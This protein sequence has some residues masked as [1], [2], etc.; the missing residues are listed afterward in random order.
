MPTYPLI[1]L[2]TQLT[3]P[4][5]PSSKGNEFILGFMGNTA[6]APIDSA[7]ASLLVTTDDPASVEFTVEYFGTTQTMEARKGDVTLVGLPVRNTQDIRVNGED[8]RNKGIRVKATDPTK[9][10]TVYGI[11]DAEVSTDAF[12]ALPCHRYPVTQYNYFVFSTNTIV[13]SMRSRFL[14]VPCEDATT[15]TLRPTQ[16]IEVSADL[17]SDSPIPQNI[18]AGEERSITVNRL[19][20]AQFNSDSDL[21]GTIIVS[22]KPI[23]VFVGHECGQVPTGR[24]ACDH[25]V[26][27]IPPD[28]TW[29]TQ[30][31]TAPLDVRES[32]ERYRVGSVVDNNQVTVTCTTEGQS[33]PSKEMTQTLQSQRGQNYMEFDTVGD[34]P[35]GVTPSYRREYCCIETTKPAIVMMYSKGHSLDEITFQGVTGSQ[36]DPFLLLIPP[37]SQYSNDYTAT[38]AK[39]VNTGFLGHI[40]LTL[41]IQFFDNSTVSRS[42]LTVNGTTYLPDSGYS[43]ILCSNNQV[44]GYGAYSELPVGSHQ[45]NYNMPGAAMNLFVYGFLREISFGYPTGF[46]MEPIGG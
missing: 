23:S 6:N 41:P 38:T 30:F 8:E 10:L 26:E 28:A 45:V 13:A 3:D 39:Q 40:S 21:T 32:G 27:Q 42:R 37:L 4:N 46:E 18:L 11:N 25:L 20:T 5:A 1:S 43:P 31:F 17:L 44:C 34:A 22:D 35:D 9:L 12:L 33:S 24:T 2:R 15:V 14:I 36:G 19:Q 7:S 16:E 29:G